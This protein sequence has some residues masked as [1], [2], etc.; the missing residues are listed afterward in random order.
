[1]PH[2][3]LLL[4]LSHRAWAPLLLL[5]CSNHPDTGRSRK[6]NRLMPPFP[7]SLDI[8]IF[9]GLYFLDYGYWIKTNNNHK[10]RLAV[11]PERGE[12]GVGKGELTVS[13]SF[14][15]TSLAEFCWVLKHQ[16]HDVSRRMATSIYC[17]H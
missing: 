14:S 1:M 3:C 9:Y 5:S 6:R 8:L 17:L 11:H 7:G 4:F 15:R 10:N 2:Y 12:R 16:F 13:H